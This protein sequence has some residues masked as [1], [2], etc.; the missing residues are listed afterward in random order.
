MLSIGTIL[1]DADTTDWDCKFLT[2]IYRPGQDDAAGNV[3]VN[4]EPDLLLIIQV[5]VPVIV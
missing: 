5:S 4:V 2:V 1:L 3:S